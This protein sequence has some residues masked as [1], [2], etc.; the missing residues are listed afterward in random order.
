MK[1]YIANKSQIREGT[2]LKRRNLEPKW[3]DNTSAYIVDRLLSTEYFKNSKYIMS[4]INF[5]NEVSTSKLFDSYILNIK[6]ICVPIIC[7]SHNC[8]RMEASRIYNVSQ[9]AI[10]KYG[11]LEPKYDACQVISPHMLDMVVVPGVA[12]DFAKNRIGYGKGYYDR[13]L[14]QIRKDCI[15]VG[16]SFDLQMYYRVPSNSYD[17]K[18]DFIVTE[19]GIF[20]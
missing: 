15:K 19:S 18:M 1:Q 9:L 8:I 5:G 17:V 20:A 12:F 11:I 4:Y 14:A 6:K 7:D 16:L 13:F 3:I 10:G 2:L